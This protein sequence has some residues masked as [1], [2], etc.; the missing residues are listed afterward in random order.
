MIVWVSF[1]KSKGKE[2]IS[3]PALGDFKLM[4]ISVVQQPEQYV[5]LKFSD[6][7]KEK[8]Y[9]LNGSKRYH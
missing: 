8:Q 2:E 1:I 4:D 6:P 9:C 3:I 7:L 5:L